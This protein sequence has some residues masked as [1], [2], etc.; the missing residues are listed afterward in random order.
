MLP[1]RAR[2]G[3]RRARKHDRSR[4]GYHGTAD[5]VVRQ[6]V[7][8]PLHWASV[9]SSVIPTRSGTARSGNPPSPNSPTCPEIHPDNQASANAS[10]PT[11]SVVTQ[12]TTIAK[13][14]ADRQDGE[15]HEGSC[16]REWSSLRGAGLCRGEILNL[17]TAR[18]PLRRAPSPPRWARAAA[19]AAA[20]RS[21]GKPE[22]FPRV[23]KR[24]GHAAATRVEVDDRSPR[25]RD[26]SATEGARNPWFLVAVTVEQD[27]RR[28]AADRQAGASRLPSSSSSSEQHAGLAHALR[29]PLLLP[30]ATTGGP[31]A[32]PKAARFEEDNPRAPAASG[33]SRAV[34]AAACSRAFS[35]APAKSAD[36]RSRRSAPAR[37]DACR[38]EDLRA[39]NANR[40]IVVVREGVVE[41]QHGRRRVGP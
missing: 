6:P 28:P 23:S 11:F 35:A 2:P 9:K 19:A 20:R 37:T 14:S 41:D 25:M 40:G 8:R 31:P 33:Y 24:S 13:A 1:G 18:D 32:A 29:L 5:R 30:R 39:R 4:P 22:V 7:E 10:T 12:L 34:L 17:M 27:R 16:R 15:V 38:I 3:W 26:N 36:G 21:S